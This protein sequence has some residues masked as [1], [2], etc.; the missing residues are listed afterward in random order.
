MKKLV[1]SLAIATS[2]VLTSC[3]SSTECENCKKDSLVVDSVKVDTTV[4]NTVP[5]ST[6]AVDSTK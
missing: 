6:V 5:T 2:V 3:G 4:V 1:L